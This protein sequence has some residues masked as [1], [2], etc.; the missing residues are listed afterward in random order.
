MVKEHDKTKDITIAIM[1]VVL[2]IIITQGMF[3]YGLFDL[4]IAPLIYIFVVMF[5]AIQFI[6]IIMR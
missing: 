3:E 6:I 4:T 1:L 5:L 2:I